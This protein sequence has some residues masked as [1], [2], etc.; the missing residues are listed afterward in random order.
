M[1]GF[2]ALISSFMLLTA[3]ASAQD[4]AV[5]EQARQGY[6]HGSAGGGV[7]TVTRMITERMHQQSSDSHS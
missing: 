5:S 1:R 7:D 6:R 3:S 4:A 2:L